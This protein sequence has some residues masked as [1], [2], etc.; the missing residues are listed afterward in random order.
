MII[1]SQS[2]IFQGYSF[3]MLQIYTV[4]Q[5]FVGLK[6]FKPVCVLLSFVSNIII[7]YGYESVTK[8]NKNFNWLEKFQT[9]QKFELQHKLYKTVTMLPLFKRNMSSEVTSGACRP[10]IMTDLLVSL[11]GS[12]SV[13]TLETSSDRRN[14]NKSEFILTHNQQLKAAREKSYMNHMNPT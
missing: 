8:E 1:V 5:C 3:K 11:N 4:V 2:R 13:T 10:Q 12:F 6:I 14:V 7:I 9:K